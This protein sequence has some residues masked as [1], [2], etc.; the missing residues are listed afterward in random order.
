MPPGY[1]E[2]ASGGFPS[3]NRKSFINHNAPKHDPT[4][5]PYEYGF[6]SLIAAPKAAAA[7]AP[8][9]PTYVRELYDPKYGREPISFSPKPRSAATA[10]APAPQ[11]PTYVRELYDPKYGRKPI[12]FSPKPSSANIVAGVY[13]SKGGAR[14]KKRKTMRRKSHR[15]KGKSRKH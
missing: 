13:G 3:Q 5:P 12:S 14:S 2:I 4:P 6:P 1:K 7:P 11:P 8:Q 9:P 15:R 10:A